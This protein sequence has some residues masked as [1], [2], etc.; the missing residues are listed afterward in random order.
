MI[1]ELLMKLEHKVEHAV[2]V[3]EL[4]RLQLEELE[5]ENAVLKVEQQK[6]RGDL[7]A[8]IKRFDDIEVPPPITRHLEV[9]QTE[10]DM[11]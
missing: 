4:L 2:E 8:L 3:I 7:V 9:E 5:E 6:W 1:A 10:F 11:A